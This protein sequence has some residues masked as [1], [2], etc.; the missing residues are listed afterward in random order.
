VLW[1]RL[2]EIAEQY[3]QK[4]ESVFVEGRLQSEAWVDKQS[5]QKRSQ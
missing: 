3:L 1:A 2:A 5:G 4:E